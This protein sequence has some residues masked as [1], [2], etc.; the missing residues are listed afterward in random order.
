MQFRVGGSG[1]IA[2][3]DDY[4][5]TLLAALQNPST[6]LP[7]IFKASQDVPVVPESAYNALAYTGGATTDT[8][9]RI[10]D[11]YLT[12]TPYGST[13]PITMA[14]KNKTIQELFDPQ[15]RMNS[16]LGVELPF[17]G[18]LIQTT[19]P[20]GYIDPTTETVKPGETQ[21][22][23][24]THNGVDTHVIHFHLVNVQVVNRVGW[25]GAIRTVDENELGWKE[26][27]RMNP[28]EDCIVAVRARVPTYPFP[29]PNSIRA[30]NPTMPVGSTFA[31]LNPITGGRLT[32]TNAMTNFGHEYV[33]HCH[34]LGHEENDMMRPLVLNTDQLLY[35]SNVGTGIWQWELGTWTLINTSVPT[36]MAASGSP[37]Y[38]LYATFPGTG[39]WKYDGSA[40][41]QLAPENPEN[42]AASGSLLYADLGTLGLWKYDGSA[43]TQLA[44][45]NPEN[46]TA[47]GSLLYADLGSFGLWKYETGSW[48]SINPNDPA[49]LAAGF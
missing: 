23:K 20:L 26:S 4:S 7:A 28:L 10:Q 9:A 19:V 3:P 6:G 8:F 37:L 43:W 39:L 27:V 31:S 2:T 15:G 32:V 44:P 46:I 24:I 16:T 30:L 22:W 25:D 48:S 12:F 1:G 34:I 11:H 42:I 17:T 13:T 29:V 40:W 35:V 5:P 14:M 21:L 49:L 18:A 45:E 41:T 47:S 38:T 33:W 36:S